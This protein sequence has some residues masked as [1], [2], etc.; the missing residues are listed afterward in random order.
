MLHVAMDEPLSHPR[1][2]L[3][4]FYFM[5]FNPEENRKSGVISGSCQDRFGGQIYDAEIRY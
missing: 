5:I 3:A 1:V 4:N 2:L